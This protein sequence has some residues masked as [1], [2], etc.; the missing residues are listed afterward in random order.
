MHCKELV[1]LELMCLQAPNA[2]NVFYPI[3]QAVQGHPKARLPCQ[4]PSEWQ[5][6]Q[7]RRLRAVSQPISAPFTPTTAQIP[8][9]TTETEEC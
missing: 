6:S 1:D 7:Q 5:S 2:V 4:P 8:D 9:H 3:S